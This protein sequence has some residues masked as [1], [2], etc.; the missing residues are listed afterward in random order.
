MV[1]YKTTPLIEWHGKRTVSCASLQNGELPM[2]LRR[3]EINKS[4]AISSSM[5]L[6]KNSDVL[7]L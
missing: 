7:Y 4:S 5:I 2:I 1:A 3:D 6:R